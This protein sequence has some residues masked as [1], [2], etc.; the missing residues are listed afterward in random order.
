LGDKFDLSGDFRWA[1]VNIKSTILDARR[2]RPQPPPNEAPRCLPDFVGRQPQIAQIVD[3]LKP[4]DRV[5]IIGIVGMGGVGKTEL[6]KVAVHRVT[7]RFADGILW[8]DCQKEEPIASASRWAARYGHEQL[9][10][11]TISA[12]AAAWRGIIS[13]RETLLI[14]DNVQPDQ[15]VEFLFPA[16]GRSAVLLTTRQRDHPD[17]RGATLINLDE[18]TPTEAQELVRE[19]LGEHVALM[20]AADARVLFELVGYLPLALAVALHLAK[21]CDWSISYL[22]D[23]LEESGALQVLGDDTRLR[24]SLRATFNLAWENLTDTL[25]QTF[26][27]LAIFNPGPDFNTEFAAAVLGLELEQ[28]R[29]RL[30]A[31]HGL[32]LVKEVGKLRWTVHPLLREF[33]E[34]HGPILNSFRLRH[35][36]HC[37]AVAWAVRDTQSYLDLDVECPHLRSALEF[38]STSGDS[39]VLKIYSYL[40]MTLASWWHARGMTDQ[41]FTWIPTA[42]E[43]SS[44]HNWQDRE[45]THHNHLGLAY[46]LRGELREAIPHHTEALRL[47]RQSGNRDGEAHSLGHLADVLLAMGNV[48]SAFHQLQIVLSIQREINDQKGQISTLGSL[49]AIFRLMGLTRDANEYHREILRISQAVGDKLSEGRVLC[50]LGFEHAE[51][52]QATQ[53]RGFYDRALSIAREIGHHS[54]EADALAGLGYVSIIDG[55]PE[56][57]IDYYSVA[58][59]IRRQVQDRNGEARSLAQLGVAY[60]MSGQLASASEQFEQ[61]LSVAREVSGR[62]GEAEIQGDLGNMYL[63]A[64]K[65]DEAIRHYESA[66][67]VFW[68]AGDE[69][70]RMYALLAL[71]RAHEVRGDTQRSIGYYEQVLVAAENLGDDFRQWIAHHRLAG[72]EA[73]RGRWGRAIRHYD[74]AARLAERLGMPRR[75]ALLLAQKGLALVATGQLDE[76]TDCL[77]EAADMLREAGHGCELARTL[78]IL[79]RVAR[80]RGDTSASHEYRCEALRLATALDGEQAESIRKQVECLL[81]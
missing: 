22:N 55:A 64:G 29:A 58:L 47:F 53:A 73:S 36:N 56:N 46:R 39:E 8:T 33:I 71:A 57:A 80:D 68:E 45:A 11:D 1:Q 42:I 4:G 17:L 75:R 6:A 41:L 61:S 14:F 65:V 3:A 18:F 16:T 31:L 66:L 9:P 69:P 54:L 50:H 67:T 26:A 62:L 51:A 7:D 12:K 40:T 79:G 49:A 43:V 13:A 35:A 48:S 72:V 74:R 63:I 37:L 32:S 2:E 21:A 70:H 24:K 78:T 60:A 52:M 23:K 81:G 25:R 19:I 5:A 30:R 27:S 59:D 44:S 38:T 76:A 15:Q 34:Y 20:R 28:A 77:T 10:G